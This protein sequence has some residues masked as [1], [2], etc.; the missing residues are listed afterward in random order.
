MAQ[1]GLPALANQLPWDVT[2]LP[3]EEI[4]FGRSAAMRPVRQIVEKVLSTDVPVLIYG[5]NG[6][7]KGL[8]ANYLHSRSRTCVGAFVKVN[9]AAIPGA[10][11]E[12]E[13]F[14]YEK[15]AFTDALRSK[16]GYVEMAERGTLFL[17]EIAD[18]DTGLQAKI[19]QLLQDGQFSRIGAREERQAK[20]RV[21]CA[22]NRDLEQEI[23]SG[24]F[25][26]DLYY[27]INTITIRLPGLGQ[28]RED[29][30]PLADYFLNKSNARFETKAPPFSDEALAMLEQ[31]EWRGNIRELENLVARYAILGSIDA[32]AEPPMPR[33]VT[34]AVRLPLDG[35]IPLK[36]IAKQAIREMESSLILRALRD[37]KWNRRKA[38]QVL[39]ISYR[40]LIYKIQEA[41]LSPRNGRK[42]RDPELPPSA[43]EVE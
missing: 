4:I 36:R 5:G 16:P 41:G 15:G 17:D 11:L 13:L 8:L 26:P 1:S 27:R 9:C 43:A 37:N 38:A 20:V 3:P 35:T 40:A 23:D 29:I 42:R 12:S 18:L 7:G 34:S 2:G 31:R 10:L 39:N 22:S 28:R 19:L 30:A 21:I 6:T 32:V 14:G 33:P 25:R 24:R